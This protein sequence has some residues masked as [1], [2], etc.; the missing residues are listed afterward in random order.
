[1]GLLD[2]LWGAAQSQLNNQQTSMVQTVLSSLGGPGGGAGE[3]NGIAAIV[4]KFQ[5]A[6]LG[7]VVQSWI[8]TEQTNQSVTPEQV[9]SALG[10]QHLDHVAQQTGMSKQALLG[11][12]A[13]LL[14]QVIDALTPNGQV[15]HDP[16]GSQGGAPS[17][18]PGDAESPPPQR[19]SGVVGRAVQSSDPTEPVQSDQDGTISV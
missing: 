17:Q 4:S 7:N 19:G 18:Q 10:D 2:Q 14:P 15:P 5:Q 13:A 8:S 6:G 9:Q 1:M 11:Q 16:P 3:A 12:L